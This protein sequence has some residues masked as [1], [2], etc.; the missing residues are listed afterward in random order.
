ML[1]RTFERSFAVSIRFSL[2]RYSVIESVQ[3]TSV[4]KAGLMIYERVPLYMRKMI[5][6][7]CQKG[8]GRKESNLHNVCIHDLVVTGLDTLPLRLAIS[9]P[10]GE[11]SEPC[12]AAKRPTAS[13]EVA[14]GRLVSLDGFSFAFRAKNGEWCDS[15]LGFQV[16]FASL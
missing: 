5:F 16:S 1:N 13:D 7:Q 15:H 12:L 2:V 9:R 14:R 11:R 8:L 3:L 6:S 4:R 10:L